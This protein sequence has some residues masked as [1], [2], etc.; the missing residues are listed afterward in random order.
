MSSLRNS[1][2][3]PHYNPLLSK[4]TSVR[5]AHLYQRTYI[6]TNTQELWNR[7]ITVLMLKSRVFCFFPPSGRG[8]SWSASFPSGMA[9]LLSTHFGFDQMQSTDIYQGC[10]LNLTAGLAAS[11]LPCSSLPISLSDGGHVHYL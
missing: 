3:S 5:C 6:L 8:L 4:H 7:E 2:L 1:G 10:P 9:W 11:W